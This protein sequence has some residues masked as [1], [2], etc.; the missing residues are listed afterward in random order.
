MNFNSIESRISGLYA[1]ADAGYCGGNIVDVV[2]K[3]LKGGCKVIQLRVKPRSDSIEHRKD[4]Y[5]KMFIAACKAASLKSQYDFTL[6]INDYPDIAVKV[7][8]DGVHVGENDA[9]VVAIKMKYGGD[10]IVGYSSHSVEEARHAAC[11]GADYVAFGAIF[12]TKTKGPGHPVQGLKRLS[13]VVR[14]AGV[15]VVAIGGIG[16]RNIGDVFEAGASAAAMISALAEADDIEA[17]TRYFVDLCS[18][19]D[20]GALHRAP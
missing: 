10:L 6:I 20:R 9:P 1:I 19:V 7:G 15:P 8:A 18:S 13:E 2:E 11:D 4:S 17:E 5:E 3:Y 14:S 12:P 16:R